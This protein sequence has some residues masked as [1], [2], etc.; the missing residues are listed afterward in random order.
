MLTHLPVM[1]VSV[2]KTDS[3]EVQ[4]CFWVNNPLGEAHGHWTLPTITQAPLHIAHTLPL[5]LHWIC[6]GHIQF[7]KST[8]T[9]YFYSCTIT[10]FANVYR[11]ELA[12]YLLNNI[13][14]G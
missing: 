14:Y 1:C 11:L 13:S 12:C 6:V 9:I 4:L 10:D 5:L 2:V 8:L 3:A 7:S